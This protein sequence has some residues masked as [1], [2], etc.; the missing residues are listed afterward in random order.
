MPAKA[1]PKNL[2]DPVVLS[3]QPSLMGHYLAELR[4][5]TVQQDRLRFRTNLRRCGWLLGY[6]LSKALAY[7]PMTI[8]TPLAEAEAQMLLE[9]PVLA[10]ILRAAL[11]VHAGFLDLFDAS[12]SAFVAAYRHHTV[13]LEGFSIRVDYLTAPDI[14]GRVLVLIDPMIATGKSM[15][16]AYQA[17]VQQAGVPAAVFGAGV[18][19]SEEGLAYV[20]LHIPGIRLYVGAVDAE[21][22]AKLYIVPGLGDA[23]DLAFGE[24]G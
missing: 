10:A 19:A 2:Y 24:K 23:G 4:D 18:I 3:Q 8:S 12:D 5:E 15:V 7:E 16:A 6:E 14:T 1:S 21:L 20:Q 9:P 17:L 13:G 22:T 11:P